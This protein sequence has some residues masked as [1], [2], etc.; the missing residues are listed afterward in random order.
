MKL[1]KLLIVLLSLLIIAISSNA[2]GGKSYNH[3]QT[4][5]V[6]DKSG[7]YVNT[8]K[9]DSTITDK[10]VGIYTD[11]KGIEYTMYESKNKKVYVLRISKNTG[12][13]YKQYL[14]ISK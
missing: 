5:I 9:S 10:P 2:Q 14:K 3:K 8:I 13:K 1:F 7:R 6:K 12:R 11:N 4:V